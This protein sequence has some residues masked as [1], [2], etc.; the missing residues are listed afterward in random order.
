MK[1]RALI[2]RGRQK[3]LHMAMAYAR[4]VSMMI[5]HDIIFRDRK[6][7]VDNTGVM[8]KSKTN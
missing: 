6:A 3:L 5:K 8:F 7:A 2:I 4:L 1:G